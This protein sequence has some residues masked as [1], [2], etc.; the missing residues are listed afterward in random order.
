[1][2]IVTNHPINNTEGSIRPAHTRRKGIVMS[3]NTMPRNKMLTRTV[4]AALTVGGMALGAAALSAATAP[5]EA[6][7]SCGSTI[8]AFSN[9]GA[10]SPNTVNF[11]SGNNVNLQGNAFGPNINGPQVSRTGNNRSRTNNSPTVCANI[12]GPSLFPRFPSTSFGSN[13]GA[14]S[15]NTFNVLS[16]NNVNAQFSGLGPNINGGQSSSTGNNN[17]TTNNSPTVSANVG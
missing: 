9:T 6:G 13:T 12:P 15:G 8:S 2:H 17:S 5:V 10:N 11:G 7:A 14:N 3:K 1:L 16:G 4:G